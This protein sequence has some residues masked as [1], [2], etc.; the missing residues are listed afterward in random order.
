MYFSRRSA[1]PV[2]RIPYMACPSLVGRG[3]QCS[4]FS[5]PS[6][7]LGPVAHPFFCPKAGQP[8]W[9]GWGT[10]GLGADKR[11]KRGNRRKKGKQKQTSR[12]RELSQRR[13]LSLDVLGTLAALSPFRLD[14][15]TR[16][17]CVLRILRILR[18]SVISLV[19]CYFPNAVIRCAPSPTQPPERKRVCAEV[20]RTSHG[21]CSVVLLSPQYSPPGSLLATPLDDA[22]PCGSSRTDTPNRAGQTGQTLIGHLPFW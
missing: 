4:S 3:T 5:E 19:F 22:S 8:H 1:Y 18:V 13:S 2:L 7:V 16:G 14:A 12:F 10:R 21:N 11:R 20:L 6:H 15:T 17:A 9:G